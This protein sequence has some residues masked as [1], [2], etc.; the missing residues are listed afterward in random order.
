LVTLA[1]IFFLYL[2]AGVL[3]ILLVN[4]L[5]K[6]LI[7]AINYLNSRK[8][9]RFKI[10]FKNVRV[11]Y[12]IIKP[13]L[14]FSLNKFL[15]SFAIRVDL[16]MISFLSTSIDVGIYGVAHQI[17]SEGIMIRNIIAMAFFPIAVKF[18]YDKSIKRKTLFTYAFALF[19]LVLVACVFVSFFVQDI[20]VLVFGEKYN[21]SGHIL[22]FLIFALSFAFYNLPLTTY[23]QATQN[24]HLLLVVPCVAAPLNISLNIVFFAKFGLIGIAYSTLVVFFTQS[25]IISLLT[26]RKSRFQ[27]NEIQTI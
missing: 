8:L 24:E 3:V 27:K 26:W 1:S 6:F 7:L 20:V 11:Q 2:G 23:L 16:I 15:E 4:L 9:I 19:F 17:A 5:S 22:I 10:N 18:F 12:N 21:E 14:I 25:L 13:T